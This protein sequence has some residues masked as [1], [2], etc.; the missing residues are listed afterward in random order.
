[1]EKQTNTDLNIKKYKTTKFNPTIYMFH[2]NAFLSKHT[3]IH[4]HI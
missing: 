3:N 1:M 2:L 4:A